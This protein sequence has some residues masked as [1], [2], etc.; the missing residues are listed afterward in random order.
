MGSVEFQRS[1]FASLYPAGFLSRKL[2]TPPP[3]TPRRRVPGAI[4]CKTCEILESSEC[5]YWVIEEAAARKS[6]RDQA[7]EK[8]S[9]CNRYFAVEAPRSGQGV[10][11]NPR[12]IFELIVF[13]LDMR[14]RALSD[15]PLLYFKKDLIN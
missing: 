13:T 15:V 4:A 11:R 6:P 12:G 3:T 14:H 5:R 7:K 9:G 2:A 1:S 8:R 10:V